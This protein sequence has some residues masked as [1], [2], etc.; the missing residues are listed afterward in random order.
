MSKSHLS[1]YVN[2][3]S[4]PD[5]HKL[6]L[7]AKT[8]KVSEAWLLGYDVPKEDREFDI[9][10]IETIYKQLNPERQTKSTTSLNISLKNNNASQKY[11]SR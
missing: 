10:A 4:Q 1:Q 6:Y 3:K 2:G 5:Q 9:P 8:L 7:L 11:Q